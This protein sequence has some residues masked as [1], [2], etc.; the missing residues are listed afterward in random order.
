M[1]RATRR[2]GQ[3][4]CPWRLGVDSLRGTRDAGTDEFDGG[5]I[6]PGAPVVSG[7]DAPGVLDAIG[8][9]LDKAALP[10]KP[11]GQCE[12]L[13]SVGSRPDIG[14]GVLIGSD[15]SDGVAVVSP[16]SEQPGALGHGVEHNF[17][18][19]TVVDAPPV[20]LKAT[21]RPSTSTMALDFAHEAASETPNAAIIGV[22]V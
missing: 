17:G 3:W 12:A 20:R 2:L 6:A 15:F 21:G 8:E 22:A 1:A 16:V 14:S 10:V 13:L 7:G 9:A 4:K 5:K 19:L 11:R 18:F